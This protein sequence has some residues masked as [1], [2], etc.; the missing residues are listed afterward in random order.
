MESDAVRVY[1]HPNT[2]IRSYLTQDEITRPLY[3]TFENPLNETRDTLAQ[4]L[5]TIGARVVQ[6]VLALPGVAQ[7]RFKPKEIRVRKTPT[8][9]WDDLEPEILRVVE[10]AVRR[11]RMRVLNR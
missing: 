7:I 11:S 8:T 6:E 5:G 9:A 1:R 4:R 2:E 3:E 10:R